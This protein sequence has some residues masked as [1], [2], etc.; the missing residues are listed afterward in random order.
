MEKYKAGNEILAREYLN[1]EDGVLFYSPLPADDPTK[2]DYSIK[3]LCSIL[4]LLVEENKNTPDS[5][6]PNDILTNIAEKTKTIIYNEKSVK[7]K[8]KK[9][10]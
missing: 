5:K 9:L 6:I 4:D 1:R 3:E 8:I 2:N 10:L 7:I